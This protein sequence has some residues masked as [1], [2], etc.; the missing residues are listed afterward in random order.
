MKS[1]LLRGLV[2]VGGMTGLGVEMAASR[3]LAPFFGTSLLVWANLI[4]LILVYLALGYWL[5]GRLADRYP[6]PGALYGVAAL[7]GFLVGLVPF[8]ARPILQHSTQ[9]FFD[10]SVSLFVGSLLATAALFS[11]P[12][13]LLGMLSPF[14]VRLS[15]GDPRTAGRDVGALYALSTLGSIVGVF[16]PVLVLIPWLGTRRT[17]LALAVALLLVALAGL[18]AHARRRASLGAAAGLTALLVLEVAAPQAVR[19]GA[20]VLFEA[21]SPY[22]FV[23]VLQTGDDRWL[24]L[25]EGQA[26]H[27]WYNPHRVLSGGIWDAFLLAPLFGPDAGEQGGRGAGGMKRDSP[28][29]PRSSAPLPPQ[30]VALLGLAAGTVAR[31]YTAVYG[32]L[33]IVGVEIDPLLIDVGRDFFGLDLPNVRPVAADARAWLQRDS[34]RYAVIAVDAYRQPYIPFHLTTVEFFTLARQR[35]SDDGVLVINVGHSLT[36]F[37][38]LDA[39]AATLRQVF[40]TV[41]A[42]SPDVAYNSLLVATVRPSRLADYTAHAARVEQPLLREVVERLEGR[43]RVWQGEGLVLTDDHAPVEQITDQIIVNYALGRGR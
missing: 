20:T 35:L 23:Q 7:A 10:A 14:A 5:G 16:L 36:D 17:F 4:G 33:P 11:L 32:P 22:H 13:I 28:L 40:P 12:V 41:Y 9:S 21:E 1:G 2:F 34:G 42:I 30:S 24:A 29:L 43:V 37:R 15:L 19:P 39:L 27:S 38:L 6:D 8:V 18:L 3:L 26:L 25:N 31:E